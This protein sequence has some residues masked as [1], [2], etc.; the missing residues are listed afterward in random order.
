MFTLPFTLSP[1]T[2]TILLVLALLSIALLLVALLIVEMRLRRFMRGG[3]GASLEQKITDILARHE[4]AEQFEKEVVRA[5]SIL[6]KRLKG[7]ARGIGTVRFDAFSGDGSGGKQS[8]A[9]AFVS[10]KG[11]GVVISSLHARGGSR[12]FAKPVSDFSSEHELTDE[13]KAAIKAAR[14]RTERS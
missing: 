10:E 12:I 9:A 8:F 1:Q 6:D 4:D 3:S 2:E 7:A 11:E 14:E 13:E 5:L